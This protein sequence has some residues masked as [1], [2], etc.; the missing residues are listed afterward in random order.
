MERRNFLRLF[1]GA[2]A[3]IALDQAIPLGRVWSFPKKIVFADVDVIRR[4]YF[5]PAIRQIAKEID[6][7]MFALYRAQ[8]ASSF[9]YPKNREN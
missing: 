7:N 8:M 5:E 3:G 1:G 9:I 2:V 6:A 4:L